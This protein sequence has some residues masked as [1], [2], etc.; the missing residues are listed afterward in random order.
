MT[1]KKNGQLK[2]GQ[3]L[4]YGNIRLD[5][6]FEEFIKT[7]K[8]GTQYAYGTYLRQWMLF[9]KLDGRATLELKRND[10]DSETEKRVIAF[11]LWMQNQGMAE[12]SSQT[13]TGALRGFFAFHRLPLTF[14]QSEKKT[15]S[16]HNRKTE[17]FLFAK[18]D[19]VRMMDQASLIE[20]YIVLVGKSIGLRASDF[21]NITYGK[22][23][24]LNLDAEAPIAIGETVT[25]KEHVKAYP[26]LDS[27][28]IP[29]VKAMLERN[30]QA[31]DSDKILDY[32]EASLTQ[33]IQRL[34]AKAHI[35]PH[36]KI[37]RFHNL[38]K[39]LIDRLSAVASESQWKQICGKKI[40][41]GAYVS[42]D[43]L[44][45]VYLRAMPSIIVNNGNGNGK[46]AVKIEALE[47]EL[48]LYKDI[49]RELVKDKVVSEG[50]IKI[51]KG[52]PT[53]PVKATKWT[54]ALE[55]LKD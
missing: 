14:I 16:E 41:E 7:K 23:R 55:K 17:D 6:V 50:N 38:R 30:P 5:S 19:I 11:K 21:I 15:L 43:Q 4:D 37:P 51:I 9:S 25:L 26:F 46:N 34:M 33:A 13:A 47:T 24:S 40:Q 39:Y 18:D 44:R 35:D 53:V 36:G 29:V 27:D 22:L 10:K 3:V 48:K 1:K 20:R 8:A 31:K 12:T 52:I 45:D 42:Q 28:A 32:S 2:A 54:D 49:L